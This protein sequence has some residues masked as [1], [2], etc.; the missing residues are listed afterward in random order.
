M[1]ACACA[2]TQARAGLVGGKRGQQAAEGASLG[3]SGVLDGQGKAAPLLFTPRVPGGGELSNPG[4][5]SRQP[6]AP[7]W[8]SGDSDGHPGLGAL[9][10]P[11]PSCLL[12]G[13]EEIPRAPEQTDS[14][15]SLGSWLPAHHPVTAFSAWTDP[16]WGLSHA[17]QHP[18]LPG[19]TNPGGQPLAAH[20][21]GT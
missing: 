5:W 10:Y 7:H 13:K 6:L 15:G 8:F 16:A 12:M 11:V 19:L 14:G 17:I 9:L 2:R 1:R 20:R 21:V 4:W 18:H 3:D